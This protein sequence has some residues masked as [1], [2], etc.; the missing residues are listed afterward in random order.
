MLSFFIL[1]YDT[2]DRIASDKKPIKNN[3]IVVFEHLT[4]TWHTL[5]VLYASFHYS[6]KV[7]FGFIEE[8]IC[9]LFIVYEQVH[10]TVY[11]FIR[12]KSRFFCCYE[13]DLRLELH[14]SDD[15]VLLHD[16]IPT[17][18]LIYKN[19][20]VWDA[21]HVASLIKILKARTLEGSAPHS[22]HRIILSDITFKDIP[23]CQSMWFYGIVFRLSVISFW[24]CKNLS[25]Q[26]LHK[27]FPFYQINRD[28]FIQQ[29]RVFLCK[30]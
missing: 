12:Y 8:G 27:N 7:L 3:W 28:N 17:N 10:G 25:V 26:M 9:R 23:F 11:I 18:R 20:T 5:E 19:G 2:V 21:I 13:F 24:N 16:K 30:I 4:W 22:P 14:C 29:Q 15:L 1:F 6:N